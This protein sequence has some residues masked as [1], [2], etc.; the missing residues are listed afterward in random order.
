MY[1]P[2]LLFRSNDRE[3]RI[4]SIEV[5]V[6]GTRIFAFRIWEDKFIVNAQE[7][8]DNTF[9]IYDSPEDAVDGGFLWL[10]KHLKKEK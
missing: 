8:L 2:E 9:D 5:D 6:E 1:L 7:L 3:F 4:E 10:K